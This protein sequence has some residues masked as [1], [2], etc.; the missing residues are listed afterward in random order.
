MYGL[1]LRWVFPTV[2]TQTPPCKMHTVTRT[3][4]HREREGV[5]E[6]GRGGEGQAACVFNWERL[7]GAV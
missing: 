2:V 3:H 7:C 6:Q 1:R 5:G 4:T